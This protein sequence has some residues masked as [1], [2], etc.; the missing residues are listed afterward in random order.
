[1]ILD[2]L[3][4]AGVKPARTAVEVLGDGDTSGGIVGRGG[5][6]WEVVLRVSAADPSRQ[7][8]ERFAREFA[9]LVTAGPPGVTGYTAGRAKPHAVLAYWPTRVSRTARESRSQGADVEGVVR[10]TKSIRLAEIAHARSGDKGNDA[11]IGVIAYTDA[12]FEHLGQVLTEARVAE[13]FLPLGPTEVRRY[14]LPG[15]RAYNFVLSNVL[16]GG[17][18][19][20]LRTDSQGKTFSLA[21]LEL[22]IPEPENV[23]RM[24]RPPQQPNPPGSP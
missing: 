22:R 18:S 10:V 3:A 12:G 15:I 5:S 14:S 2:R 16:A 6:P 21:L 9:P 24:R 20:S 17:A 1:M 4:A 19:R 23:D 7:V 11:N 13:Y 8:V